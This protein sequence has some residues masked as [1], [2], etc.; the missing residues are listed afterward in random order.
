M[1]SQAPYRVR[2]R[3][4]IEAV[5]DRATVRGYWKGDNP[6]HWRGHLDMLLTKQSKVRKVK[7]HASIPWEAIGPLMAELFKLV[8][9]V[10]HGVSCIG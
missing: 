4:R 8:V 5:V 3:G 10:F 1:L 7:H 2:L 6:A 9:Q